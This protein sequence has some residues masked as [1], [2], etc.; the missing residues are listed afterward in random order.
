MI[1]D[2]FHKCMSFACKFVKLKMEKTG[3]QQC[4]EIIFKIVSTHADL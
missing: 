3:S 4:Q 2:R 1:C